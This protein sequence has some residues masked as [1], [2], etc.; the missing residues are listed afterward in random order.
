MRSCEIYFNPPALFFIIFYADY[1]S[2]KICLNALHHQRT[3]LAADSAGGPGSHNKIAFWIV[4]TGVKQSESASSFQYFSRRKAMPADRQAFRTRNS[5]FC[6]G[7]LFRAFFNKFAF[8]II[9]ARDEF[10]E[11]AFPFHKFSG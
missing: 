7:F 10:S 1:D 9:A 5:G 4:G 8:W 6:P 11:S 2:G 3:A